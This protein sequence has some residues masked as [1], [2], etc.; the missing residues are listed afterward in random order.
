[1]TGNDPDDEWVEVVSQMRLADGQR[2]FESWLVEH[3][4]DRKVIADDVRQDVIR[5][6]DGHTYTRYLVRRRGLP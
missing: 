1:M 2:A 5:G 4:L 6:V 3:E